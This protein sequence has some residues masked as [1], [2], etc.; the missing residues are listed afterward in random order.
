MEKVEVK[1][2]FGKPYT[3]NALPREKV[4]EILFQDLD[5]GSVV[6][7]AYSAY[8]PGCATGVAQLNVENGKLIGATY[9]TG[10]GDIQGMQY[11]DIYWVDQNLDLPL[12]DLLD[13]EEILEYREVESEVGSVEEFC[14]R[15]GID[16][17]ERELAA[18]VDYAYDSIQSASWESMIEEQLDSIYGTEESEAGAMNPANTFLGGK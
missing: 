8:C 4:E 15:A 17:S 7:K 16:Y 1:D 12:E 6:E 2:A 11:I 10:S 9:T 3:V 14:E 13:E 18:L 5:I